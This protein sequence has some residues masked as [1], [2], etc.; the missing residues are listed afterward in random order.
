[1]DTLLKLLVAFL[2]ILLLLKLLKKTTHF[3]SKK[4]SQQ[5]PKISENKSQHYHDFGMT[6][7]EINFFRETMSTA[8]DQ[9]EELT[10]YTHELS[11][12][13]AINLRH[14]TLNVARAMFKALVAE[15]TRLHLADQFLYTDLPSLVEL[16]E[17]YI[18]VNQHEIK[19]RET[20]A[21]LEESAQA[22]DTLSKKIVTDYEHFVAE[23][24]EDLEIEIA[25]AK[26][27]TK[28]EPDFKEEIK[29]D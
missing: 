26:Q 8:K 12:L 16:S 28:K 1:M 9:I 17:K 5:L 3:R 29:H 2:V 13:Q 27:H 20:Y 25:Y 10:T 4:H 21:K 23:D 6:D 18:Q 15:P 11:K 14:D 22:I 7:Q 19:N 24:L